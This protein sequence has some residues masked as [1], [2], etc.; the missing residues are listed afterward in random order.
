MAVVAVPSPKS[1]K[2]LTMWVELLVKVK[3]FPERHWLASLMLN[4]GVCFG[5]T[6]TGRVKVSLQPLSL[7]VINV[8]VYPPDVA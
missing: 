1:H 2:L 5:I 3:L 6:F 7:V 4:T 8:T